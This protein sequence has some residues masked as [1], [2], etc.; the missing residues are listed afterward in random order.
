MQQ[1]NCYW[2]W[3][4]LMMTVRNSFARSRRARTSTR[5]K[6]NGMKF[7]L[8]NFYWLGLLR[9]SFKAGFNPRLYCLHSIRNN[10]ASD[11]VVFLPR[12]L[13]SPCCLVIVFIDFSPRSLSDNRPWR[14]MVQ[15]TDLS[16]LKGEIMCL[17][18]SGN[19]AW[20]ITFPPS[21]DLHLSKRKSNA[22]I[23]Q[24]FKSELTHRNTETSQWQQGFVLL[25]VLGCIG[26]FKLCLPS[27]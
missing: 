27:Y 19:R 20:I 5:L 10:S 25:V 4:W 2:R 13:T 15:Q 23:S 1:T 7:A 22:F 3:T 8:I 26:E 21:L 17:V 24:Q 16:P 14:G 9:V 11:V 12:I 6:R 18:R